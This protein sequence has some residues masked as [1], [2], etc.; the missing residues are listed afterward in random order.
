MTTA[1]EQLQAM[2]GPGQEDALDEFL[3][4][5]EQQDAAI[6]AAEDQQG[7][8][9]GETL[10]AGKFKSPEELERGY[11]ELQRKL[12]ERGQDPTAEESSAA[13]AGPTPDQYTPEL[14]KQLYGD[15]VAA[16]I[17]AAQINPLEMAQRVYAGQDVAPYVDALVEKGGLPRDLV[18][19]YLAGVAPAPAAGAD[20]QALTPADEAELK[21]MV[22][23]EQQFQELGKWALANLSADELADYNAA[24]DSGNKAAAR[25]AIRQ[26]H[27]RSSGGEKR[28]PKLISGGAPVTGDVFES[29][30]QAIDA[31]TKKGKD[32]RTLYESDPTYRAWYEKTL[33][34][35]KVFV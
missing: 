28:E 11:L 5:V 34:R 27:L 25:F 12:G 35:S 8:E 9:S 22:G 30:Q 10:L 15:T 24:I 3:K 7:E 23:G 1:P 18:E 19:T 14:G 26:L 4:E 32:G 6:A 2:V 29:D 20:A 33:S 13:Q 31:R 16:A 21:A 17:E